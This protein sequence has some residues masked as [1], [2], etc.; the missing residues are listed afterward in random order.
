MAISSL[1]E[2]H[3]DVLI[4]LYGFLSIVDMLHLRQTSRRLMAISKLH[5]V[6]KRAYMIHIVGRGIPFPDLNIDTLPSAELEHLTRRASAIGNF[7]L[8]FSSIPLQALEFSASHGIPVSDI[9]FVPANPDWLVTVSR[10]I[11]FRI[12]CW[13]T[14]LS[15]IGPHRKVADWSPKGAIFT[16]IIVNSDPHSEAILAVSTV[17]SNECRIDILRMKPSTPESSRRLECLATINSSFK[18]MNLCGDLLAIADETYEVHIINWRTGDMAMLWGSDEPSEYNFQHNR[19]LQVVFSPRCVLVMRARSFEAF[20]MPALLPP[21]TIKAP[22]HPVARHSFGWIDGV[23]VSQGCPSLN[24]RQGDLQDLS[25]VLRAESDDPWAFSRH[26]VDLYHLRQT[27]Q[28]V[29]DTDEDNTESTPPLPYIFPPLHHASFP[30][31]R[32]HLRCKDIF[33]GQNGTALWIQPRPARNS[34]LTAFDVH[35]SDAQGTGHNPLSGSK[36]PKKESLVTAV[37]PGRLKSCNEG[38]DENVRT[39]WTIDDVSVDWTSMDYDEA[40]GLIA[41]GDSRGSVV[42][43]SLATG[44]EDR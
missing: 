26:T 35:S 1:Q 38:I 30:S 28:P 6:W 27:P 22:H 8:N 10:G 23:A 7:W 44:S 24:S 20:A 11:W 5:I 36:I 19:C 15:R 17:F 33:L 39:L 40:R 12:T 41:L 13:D 2:L 18:V 3:D 43:L 25:I 21:H 31:A 4:Y 37:F 34:D 29:E 32:G 9:H 42:I 16:G 14:G